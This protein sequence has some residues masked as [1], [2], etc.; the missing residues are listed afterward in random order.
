[1]STPRRSWRQSV[2]QSHFERLEARAVPAALPLFDILYLSSDAAGRLPGREGLAL[3]Y[4]D[5]DILRVTIERNELG[6]LLSVRP[7]IL[8]DGS[9]VGLD[10]DSED[11]DALAILPDGRLLIS[12][13]GKATV[14][15]TTAEDEDLL[16]F[17]PAAG[18]LGA[19]TAGTWSHFFD[20]SDVGLTGDSEDLDAIEVLADGRLVI[21]TISDASV[22]GA[23]GKS[24]SVRGEDLLAFTPTSLGTTTKGTWAKYFDGSNV[25]L[26]SSTEK[27]DALAIEEM[28]AI[29]AAVLHLSTSGSFS[30]T[31]AS[32]QDED[33]VSYDLTAKAFVPGLRFDG[34]AIGL[35]SNADIDA[36]EV[37]P[38]VLD[39]IDLPQL[40]TIDVAGIL[41]AAATKLAAHDARS[42][43]KQNY[44]RE[45]SLNQSTWTTIGPTNWEGGFYPGALWYLYEHTA[46]PAWQARAEAWTAGLSLQQY[47]TGTHDVGFIIGCSFGQGLRLTD[48]PAYRDVLL[49]AA[50][51]LSSRFNSAVGA[52][53]SW[54]RFTFPVIIDNLMNL[55]LLFWAAKNGGTTASGGDAQALFDMAVSHAAKTL[56][57]HVRSD[58][59]TYH[60]V[61]YNPTSG[62]VLKRFTHQGKSNESTW[63]RGQAWAIYGFTMTYRETGDSQ[64]LDAARRTADYFLANL[65]DDWVPPADFQSTYQDLA[66]KDSSAA[67]IAASGLIELSQLETDPLRSER[68]WS[69][70]TNILD[71][72]ASPTYLSSDSKN[73][74]LLLHGARKYPGE[75]RSYM[76]GDYYFVEAVMRYQ[77]TSVQL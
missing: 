7:E 41:S 29:D 33:V 17:T 3:R 2:R 25:G 39:T 53:R 72:L 71:S 47:N 49:T 58:G 4:D 50:R 34:S 19:N 65:P 28:G 20:G 32:G 31:G 77:A 9:D 48:N 64:F 66:H 56:Q 63:S 55:E 12:T 10:A 60:V 52:T 68:Y 22:T 37:G 57:N 76:F 44:P 38:T 51:S 35:A 27:V 46:D 18:G 67:A 30:V 24:I 11:I 73:A 36:I 45:H 15:G 1:M 14:P 70:A 26:A 43:T 21:S 61:D 5:S 54:D 40:P 59:S 42:T 75:N 23:T 13:S 62:A 8:F 6:E 69:A 16:L 74:G